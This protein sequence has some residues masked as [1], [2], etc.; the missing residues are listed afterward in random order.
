MEVDKLQITRTAFASE[1]RVQ[2]PLALNS[3]SKAVLVTVRVSNN[4]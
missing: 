3:L 1:L 2:G 4:G